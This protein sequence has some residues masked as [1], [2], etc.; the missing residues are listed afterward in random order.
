MKS[1][2]IYQSV[3]TVTQLKHSA[4]K[5]QDP[6]RDR[7]RGSGKDTVSTIEN[8]LAALTPFCPAVKEGTKSPNL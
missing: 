6:Q 3:L 7:F 8:H 1:H 4:G 5:S 2:F